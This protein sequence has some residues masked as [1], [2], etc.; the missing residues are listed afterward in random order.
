MVLAP[1]QTVPAPVRTPLPYGLFSVLTFRTSNDP[2][3]QGGV[4]WEPLSCDPLPPVLV[5]NCDPATPNEGFPKQFETGTDP[6]EADAF[7]VYGT[8]QCNPVGGGDGFAQDQATQRLLAGEEAQVTQR[9][10]QLFAGD[11]TTPPA[12]VDPATALG[13]A[14]QAIAA[15]YGA[16]GLII[17]DRVTA[18]TLAGRNLLVSSGARLQTQLGTPVVLAPTQMGVDG[19][20]VHGPT[21]FGYRSEVFT[22]SNQQGDLF[23]R[24]TNTL[25]AI[26]ERTYLL[27]FDPCGMG[28]VVATLEVA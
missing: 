6:A 4:Q 16:Q 27:G 1:P 13:Q 26:A 20:I 24:S 12:A 11:L 3:W 2:H 17:V 9:L 10:A 18:A 7:T 15:E 8:Y 22:S 28:A 5:V 14:E 25:T 21:P 19:L 23:D